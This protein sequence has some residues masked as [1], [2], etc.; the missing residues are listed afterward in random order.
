MTAA[1]YGHQPMTQRSKQARPMIGLVCP[2]PLTLDP[3]TH[4]AV[5]IDVEVDERNVDALS[6]LLLYDPRGLSAS[7]AGLLTH[8]AGDVSLRR[9]DP[10]VVLPLTPP[11]VRRLN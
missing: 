11:P 10:H 9:R 5:L 8:H 2:W 1:D 6:V 4:L 7:A 3:W